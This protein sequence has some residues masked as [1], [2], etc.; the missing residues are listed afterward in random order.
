MRDTVADLLAALAGAPEMSSMLASVDGRSGGGGEE[1]FHAESTG[2]DFV[3]DPA[4]LEDDRAVTDARSLLEVRRHH[5]DG[6]A[7]G[8]RLVEQVVDGGPGAD[9]DACR[10]VFEDEDGSLQMQPPADHGLLLVA[11]G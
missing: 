9:V 1:G 2:V 7:G 6:D 10:R 11:A 3:G 4:T 5:Q 8:D